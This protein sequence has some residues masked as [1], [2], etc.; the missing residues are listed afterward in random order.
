ME[1]DEEKSSTKISYEEI[2]KEAKRILLV[3]KSYSVYNEYG[4]ELKQMEN[5]LDSGMRTLSKTAKYKS[6]ILTAK[7]LTR[8]IN[9]LVLKTS[10]KKSDS[11]YKEMALELEQLLAKLGFGL[12]EMPVGQIFDENLDEFLANVSKIKKV[13]KQSEQTDKTPL[14]ILSSTF[15]CA[16]NHSDGTKKVVEKASVELCDVEPALVPIYENSTNE[17]S[18]RLKYGKITNNTPSYN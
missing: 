13:K 16:R 15:G 17:K 18:K 8:I 1:N 10:G 14:Y 3:L 11:N 7:I 4:D 5:V 6:R 9:N 12:Y 2:V